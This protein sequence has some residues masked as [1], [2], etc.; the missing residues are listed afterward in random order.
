VEA[1]EGHVHFEALL[2]ERS[3]QDG[4]KEDERNG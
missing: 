1:E 4:R 3:E 2:V